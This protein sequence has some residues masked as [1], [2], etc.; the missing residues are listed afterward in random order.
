MPTEPRTDTLAAKFAAEIVD[1]FRDKALAFAAQN[2][3]ALKAEEVRDVDFKNEAGTKWLPREEIYRSCYRVALEDTL[4]KIGA[5]ESF[6]IAETA[7]QKIEYPSNLGRMKSKQLRDHA[8]DAAGEALKDI[9]SE[10]PISA[11]LKV[12]RQKQKSNPMESFLEAFAGR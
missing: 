4:I 12:G 3:I 11:D 9:I 5:T 10:I 2:F 6:T 1:Q 8:Y 7:A